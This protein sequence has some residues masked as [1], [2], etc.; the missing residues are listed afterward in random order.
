[1]VRDEL[2]F[3]ASASLWARGFFCIAHP[4]PFVSLLLVPA[5]PTIVAGHFRDPSNISDGVPFVVY[6]NDRLACSVQPPDLPSLLPPFAARCA[7]G[8]K[9]LWPSA[10]YHLGYPN[11]SVAETLDAARLS[12][13]VQ[14]TSQGRVLQVQTVCYQ[15]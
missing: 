10:P 3:S 9:Q 2:A 7:I 4:T 11:A 5:P 15:F 13:A 1:L 14:A 6:R 8:A 12:T